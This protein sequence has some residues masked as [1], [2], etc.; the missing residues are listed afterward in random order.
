MK[1]LP[2]RRPQ[3]SQPSVAGVVG[4]SDADEDLLPMHKGV[5][6]WFFAHGAWLPVRPIEI[7]ALIEYHG[8]GGCLRLEASGA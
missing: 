2:A 4:G 6:K 3:I 1:D 5:S 7:V 8:H